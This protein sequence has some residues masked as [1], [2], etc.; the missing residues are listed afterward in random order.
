MTGAMAGYRPI[1]RLFVA[2]VVAMLFALGVRT[3][4]AAPYS[5]PSESMEP[6]LL[7]GDYVI[8]TKWDY[9]LRAGGKMLSLDALPERGDV[10]MFDG[11]DGRHYVKRVI[12]L[13][14]DQVAMR[15]G[16]VWL[17]G[18]PIRRQPLSD[19]TL[20]V[21]ANMDA[22]A[23]G[24][25]QYSPCFSPDFE[26]VDDDGNRACRFRRFAE[27]LADGRRY[28]TVDL[29]DGLRY[30]E[31][32]PVTV[33]M[34]S[35]FVMGDNRDRSADSRQPQEQIGSV[36]FVKLEQV[37]GRAAFI[38]FSVDGSAQIGK[39]GSWFGAIRWNRLFKR[40]Q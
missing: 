39:P 40:V 12:G 14:G 20:P 16:R 31:M 33:P 15:G 36:G 27:T 19:L 21:T 34:G 8:A 29:F 32:P 30:D 28:V 25:S 2:I 35:L 11:K 5:I 38:I 18:E 6:T 10:I 37:T 26:T 4:I 22:A 7:V 23:D 13:P 3:F 1:V 17:N 24:N 9:G